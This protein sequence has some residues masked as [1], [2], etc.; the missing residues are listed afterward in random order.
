MHI[1]QHRKLYFNIKT[2]FVLT[3][4]E[5]KGLWF[6]DCGY[7]G[8][9]YQLYI[10]RYILRVVLPAKIS[11]MVFNAIFNNISC[12]RVVIGFTTCAISAYHP[13]RGKVY[14]IQHHVI[15]FVSDLR[16]VGGFLLVLQFPSSI[17][18]TATIKQKKWLKSQKIHLNLKILNHFFK[19]WMLSIDPSTAS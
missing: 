13:A 18:L 14:L 5:R 19:C 1:G 6:T 4:V 3:F 2:W 9:K 15:K 16:Q 11:V 8:Y 17:K 7:L 10:W 12:D